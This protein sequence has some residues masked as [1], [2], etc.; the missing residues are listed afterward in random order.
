MKKVV[1]MDRH[2][3]NLGLQAGMGDEWPELFCDE[4]FMAMVTK[5]YKEAHRYLTKKYGKG[6]K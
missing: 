6:N 3:A 4:E 5:H 1:V 2:I